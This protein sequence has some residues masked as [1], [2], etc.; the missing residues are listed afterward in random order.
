[1]RGGGFA[2][3]TA[4]AATQTLSP[5]TVTAKQGMEIVAIELVE[6]F[7]SSDGSLISTSVTVGDGGSATRFLSAT[8]LN[9]AGTEIYLK[10]G[11]L[12]NTSLPYVYTTDD[13][14]DVFVTCTAG[15]NCNTHTAGKVLIY[16][17]LTDARVN[18]N[19]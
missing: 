4:A 19:L 10:G 7:V 1:L 6:N 17:R 18:V 3:L 9:D 14:V 12:A 13:T 2:D 16:Y 5:I 15:H 11:T 8:E